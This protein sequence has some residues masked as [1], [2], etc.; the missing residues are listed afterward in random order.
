M[1]YYRNA[2]LALGNSPSVFWNL[3]NTFMRAYS[4]MCIYGWMLGIGD[5]HLK[6]TLVCL[7]TGNCIG[8]K[9][10]YFKTFVAAP[11]VCV[12]LNFITCLIFAGIDFGYAFG[13]GVECTRIPELIPFRMTPHIKSI[14]APMYLTG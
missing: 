3:R 12:F 11:T 7:K 10:T 2:L 4:T 6:N 8:K 1:I 5:R 9:L 13:A 14:M